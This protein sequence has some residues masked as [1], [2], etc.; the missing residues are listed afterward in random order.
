MARDVTKYR[1]LA[2]RGLED[3]TKKGKQHYVVVV[4]VSS[5]QLNSGARA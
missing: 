1:G 2:T 4:V 3:K 5:E